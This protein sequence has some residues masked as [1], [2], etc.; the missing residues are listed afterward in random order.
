LT[1]CGEGL[2]VHDRH[3]LMEQLLGPA[4]L[5]EGLHVDRE[6]V[7]DPTLAIAFVINARTRSSR[8]SEVVGRYVRG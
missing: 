7:S 1:T 8:L 3:A 2:A 5:S 6:R 4:L